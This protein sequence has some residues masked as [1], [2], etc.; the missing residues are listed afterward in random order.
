[1]AAG[2]MGAYPLLRFA[3]VTGTVTDAANGNPLPGVNVLLSNNFHTLT[4]E[5]GEYFVRVFSDIYD[6]RFE[7]DDYNDSVFTDLEI[8]FNDTLE[9]NAGLLHPEFAIS[10]DGIDLEIGQG[11]NAA[12]SLTISN[13]AN[14]DLEWSAAYD[15]EGNEDAKPFQVR[16][17][18]SVGEAFND[19][20]INGI[21]FTGENIYCSGRDGDVHYIYALDS[22]GE[23]IDRFEQPDRSHAG[24]R[25]LTWDGELLWGAGADSIYASITSA[26]SLIAGRA[27]TIRT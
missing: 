14:G 12:G 24:I 20:R 16:R 11:R 15:L 6:V 22:E 21:A 25:G 5:N 9:V 17:T 13:A 19:H 26:R 4:D 23:P 7:L 18:I 1:M 27:A 10:N 8:G 3:Y 2:C